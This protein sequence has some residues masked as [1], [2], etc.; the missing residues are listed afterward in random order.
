MKT[1]YIIDDSE[2]KRERIRGYL[3]E[4]FPNAEF[5]ELSFINEG[6]L[7]ICRTDK[8]NIIDNP[9]EHLVVIDMLMPRYSDGEIERNAG[10]SVLAEMGRCRLACPALIASSE[11]VDNNRATDFYK[12]YLG[13]V[14]EDSSVFCIPLYE[15]LLE[16]YLD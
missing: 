11:T 15:K 13:S 2:F 5:V 6:L 8:Q 3:E 9:S 12:Y 10:Y 4:L 16:D 1:I 14:K 7:R